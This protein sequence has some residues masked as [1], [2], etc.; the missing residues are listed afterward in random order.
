[1]RL[2]LPDALAAKGLWTRDEQ[3]LR[4]QL[5]ERGVDTDRDATWGQLVDHAL[6]AFVEPDLVEPTIVHDY[7]VELSPFARTTDD[8]DTL[9]ERFEYFVARMELGNAF[10][11]I[12][13]A[14]EQSTRFEMQQAE[15][16]AGDALA[17]ESDPDYLEALSYGMPPT[18][19]IGL[20][21]D[22]LVMLFTGRETIRDV[23]LFP[24]L[25]Q[26]S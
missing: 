13:T 18:G 9:V 6:S 25:R 12:N 2:R 19:G 20:G 17:E 4:A 15:R 1:K 11:E 5:Q 14:A 8:D 24:A 22:R 21:I 23:V 3:E 7:P 10:T 26:T 16:E